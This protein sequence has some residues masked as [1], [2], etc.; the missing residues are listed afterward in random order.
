MLL[1]ALCNLTLLPITQSCSIIGAH[2]MP[3]LFN[4]SSITHTA[5]HTVGSS[6]SRNEVHGTGKSLN[7]CKGVRGNTYLKCTDD[8][9]IYIYIFCCHWLK[10][11]SW[12]S[13]LEHR[14]RKYG[15]WGEGT[16]STILGLSS[17][18]RLVVK[19]SCST[20]TVI[21]WI[22]LLHTGCL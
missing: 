10:M 19:L 9:Y 2:W 21:I 17:L 22:T 18:L 12:K 3:V 5:W 14:E 16:Y 1:M 15:L 7:C 6:T 13:L 8:S 20:K 11:I 4:S